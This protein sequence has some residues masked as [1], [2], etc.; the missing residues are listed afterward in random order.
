MSVL[1]EPLVKAQKDPP[2]LDV[3]LG[4]QVRKVYVTVVMAILLG[5]G[6]CTDMLCGRVMSHSNTLRLSRA[7][8]TPSDAAM[9]TSKSSI[10]IK[11]H[12]IER[13][14]RA[15]LF[16]ASC[17]RDGDS[18]WNVF[19]RDVLTTLTSRVKHVSAAKRRCRIVTKIL[20]KVL[21]SFGL[22]I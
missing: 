14:T 19:L 13:V 11:S 12:V 7:T 8:F 9:D 20:K 10:W 3:L 21:L 18:D 5:D 1:L 22:C 16:D 4:N 6:K 17:R 15:A 2:L